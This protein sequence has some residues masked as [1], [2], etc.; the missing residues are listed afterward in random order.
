MD[1]QKGC[2]FW[3]IGAL[4]LIL[5]VAWLHDQGN[6]RPAMSDTQFESRMAKERAERRQRCIDNSK[7]IPKEFQKNAAEIIRQCASDD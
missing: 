2:T 3:M 7:Y 1:G 6:Q 5:G 4:A